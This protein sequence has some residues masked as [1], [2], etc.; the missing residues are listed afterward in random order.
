MFQ[1]GFGLPY[2]E[3]TA[4]RR[5]LIARHLPNIAPDLN[6]F[7]FHFPQAYNELL[8]S[9][10]MFNWGAERARQQ[11]LFRQWLTGVPSLARELASKPSLI[12]AQ[13]VHPVPFSR[14]TLTA[15]L[16][17]LS[18]PARE[19][20]D[21]CRPLN[22]F[23]AEWRQCAGAGSL[24]VT[25]WPPS[26]KRWLSGNAYARR[27]YDALASKQDRPQAVVSPAKLQTDFIRTKMVAVNLYP[28]L[29]HTR[30]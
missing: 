26:A 19:T 9:P 6:R 28:L 17:V 7:G 13:R 10:E 3:A 30:T 24:R 1:E 15:Q 5:P 25:P 8:I 29:W 11:R 14:L 12:T 23:L 20:W 22:P 18:R 2:L 21:A 4:A 27:F 16:E